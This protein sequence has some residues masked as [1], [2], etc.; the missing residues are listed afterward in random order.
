MSR[1]HCLC[2]SIRSWQF[3]S[4]FSR[5]LESKRSISWS[6]SRRIKI[7]E[8]YQ[9][10]LTLLVSGHAQQALHFGFPSGPSSG[11]LVGVVAAD[12]VCDSLFPIVCEMCRPSQSRPS[13]EF[14]FKVIANPWFH[15]N[16][17]YLTT[18][19]FKDRNMI[20]DMS[21]TFKLVY[22]CLFRN[23]SNYLE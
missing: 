17:S 6:M 7:D 5:T 16:L 3:S 11:C 21:I 1:I 14:S 2:F 15:N 22:S 8:I 12:T 20:G 9:A 10:S 19:G 13:H 4:P 18:K 23:R